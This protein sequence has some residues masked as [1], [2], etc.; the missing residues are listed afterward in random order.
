MV[1]AAAPVPA[2]QVCGDPVA[3]DFDLACATCGAPHHRDCHAYAGR[4]SIYGCGGV[5]TV[6][7]APTNGTS[8]VLDVGTPVPVPAAWAGWDRRL[9]K[10]AA[11][12]PRTVPLALVA[13]LLPLGVYALAFPT[14]GFLTSPF[15]PNILGAGLL[16]GLAAPLVAPELHRTPGRALGLALGWMGLRFWLGFGGIREFGPWLHSLLAVVSILMN[17]LFGAAVAELVAGPRSGAP[18]WLSVRP[19]RFLISTGTISATGLLAMLAVLSLD[20]LWWSLPFYLLSGFWISL[21]AFPVLETS[22]ADYLDELPPAR[23]G[24]P[25]GP[26]G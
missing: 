11:R 9:A 12:W 6:R 16:I 2:C 17:A 10:A 1:A 23:R 21:A 4:C 20:Q 19:V 7:F 3:I 5:A 25:G 22:K 15:V 8:L 18:G 14:L 13:A 26:R 24:L